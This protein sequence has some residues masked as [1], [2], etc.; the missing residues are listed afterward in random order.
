VRKAFEL[1]D[2]VTQR[3]RYIIQ[4]EYY[5]SVENNTKKAR[6]IYEN[7]LR[8][9][10]NDLIGTIKLGA[11]YVFMEEWDKS[12]ELLEP[13]I[14]Q[15]IDTYYPYVYA[16][17]SYA[18][19]GWYEK[20]IETL[21]Y[22]LANN[23]ENTLLR[24]QLIN[25]YVF[26]G[27]YQQAMIE[28]EKLY[29]TDSTRFLPHSKIKA[30]IY[31]F[32]E[33]MNKA[34]E[35][36]LNLFNS[37]NDQEQ[38]R[39]IINLSHLYPLLGK[40]ENA[41]NLLKQG[42]QKAKKLKIGFYQTWFQL[43]L[44]NCL[45]RCGKAQEAIRIC[46]EIEQLLQNR[47]DEVSLIEVIHLKGS[48]LADLNL[49]DEAQIEANRLSGVLEGNLNQKLMRYYFDLL[50]RIEYA[51]NDFPM[52]KY[53]FEKAVSLL[54]YEHSFDGDQGL[55]FDSSASAFYRMG[56]LDKAISLYEELTNLTTGRLSFGDIYAKS[57]YMLGK[58]YNEQGDTIQAIR[59]YEKFLDLWKDADPGIVEVEDA[60]KRLAGLK[61]Q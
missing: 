4:A 59:H 30:V 16:A 20:A 32:R 1:S 9:Y 58:I 38:F 46:A 3:E 34:E 15:D 19:K 22:Y 28:L 36:L 47:F 29:P 33:E 17:I 49:I 40:Y 5:N 27:D 42:I 44:A 21:N 23:S 50:G 14:E 55:F 56:D 12:I 8:I 7:L 52:T 45:F 6:E 54:S 39:G 18:G 35:E 57:F 13:S 53:N 25:T 37:R 31:T 51:K 61:N 60:K 11:I 48:I 41:I 26:S 2:R 24:R 43:S 10:P